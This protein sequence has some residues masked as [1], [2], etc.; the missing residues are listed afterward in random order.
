[1][2]NVPLSQG[3]R[4]RPVNSELPN[5]DNTFAANV[6]GAP[7]SFDYFAPKRVVKVQVVMTD[8]SVTASTLSIIHNGTPVNV[9]TVDTT[10]LGDLRFD[11]Y[12]IDLSAY[13]G[14]CC[15]MKVYSSDVLM[16]QSENFIVADI[17][18][19]KIIEWFNNENAF[20]MNYSTGLTH[21]LQIDAKTWKLNFGGE[22]TVYSNQGIEVKLKGTVKRIFLLENE[23]P[24]YLCEILTL[25]MEHDHF[26]I[27]SV[28]YVVSKKPTITQLGTSGMYS[29][30]AEVTQNVVVGI[31][32]HGVA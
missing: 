16:Y 31:N 2:I 20:Q 15:Y 9:T 10:Y 8:D 7:Y 4:F 14:E 29:F 12:S 11:T 22:S 21:V 19:Y 30:S 27:N 25:A 28:E 24:D 3:F 1:M 13:P 23:L 18:G 17:P 32:T 26:Y 5:F 6:E